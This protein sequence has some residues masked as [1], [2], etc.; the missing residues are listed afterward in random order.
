MK[1][2]PRRPRRWKAARTPQCQIPYN[3]LVASNLS[4][5]DLL[6][7]CY[8][9]N[10]FVYIKA[11][12]TQDRKHAPHARCHHHQGCLVQRQVL[13]VDSVS[14]PS[15]SDT[16]VIILSIDVLHLLTD[17]LG[18]PRASLIHS[19]IREAISRLSG[20]WRALSFVS[21]E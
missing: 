21:S 9:P 6:H 20:D 19:S 5:M 15:S 3:E 17:F 8:P 16:P 14:V 2:V 4:R 7:V 10:H 12:R 11:T 13:C 1:F 18:G